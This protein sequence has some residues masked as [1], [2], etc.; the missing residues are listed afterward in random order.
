MKTIHV[1]FN[2]EGVDGTSCIMAAYLDKGK[3]DEVFERLE[4]NGSIYAGEV[5]EVTLD[6]EFED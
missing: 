2:H 5:V 6:K 1:I 4:A 3:A